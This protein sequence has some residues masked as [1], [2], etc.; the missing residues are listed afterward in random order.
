[1]TMQEIHSEYSPSAGKTAARPMREPFLER[2]LLGIPEDVANSFTDAQL[3]AV[4]RSFGGRNNRAH[5]VDMHITMPLLFQSYYLVFL[6]GIEIRSRARRRRDAAHRPIAKV[7][8]R[9]F[10]CLLSVL[11]FFIVA[12]FLSVLDVDILPETQGGIWSAITGQFK[13]IF[14]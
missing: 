9:V 2:F 7:A 10:L 5:M 12:G 3:A 13:N 14:L 6:T 4:K 8:N 1:M 11:A